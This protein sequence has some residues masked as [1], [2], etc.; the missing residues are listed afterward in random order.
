MRIYFAENEM[1]FSKENLSTN[2]FIY[3]M[4]VCLI[5]VSVYHSSKSFIY[6]HLRITKCY[7]I[8]HSLNDNGIKSM[9][10]SNITH[11]A[12]SYRDTFLCLKHFY[13]L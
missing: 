2:S 12:M 6:I 7:S 11:V 5:I 10:P 4:A 13:F 9:L 3:I 8:S 1:S